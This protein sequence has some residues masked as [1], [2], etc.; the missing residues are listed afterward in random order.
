MLNDQL[1]AQLQA[2]LQKL[3]YPITLTGTISNEP[4]SAEVRSLLETIGGLSEKVSVRFDGQDARSPSFTVARDG[5]DMSLR[6]AAV[7]LGHEFTSL[8]LALL[9][10]GGHPPKVEA[11]VIES[12][13]A[14]DGDYS[15]EVFNDDYQQMPP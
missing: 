3:V 10:A 4:S 7:P 9:W 1:K 8:V 12:I 5:T 6:F 15:F 13:Q 11:D 2:Y 14:L